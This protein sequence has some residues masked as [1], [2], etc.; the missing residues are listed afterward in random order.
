MFCVFWR[1]SGARRGA[2]TR[3][4][5]ARRGACTR[6]P[7]VRVRFAPSPTGFLH[8]G[9]LRTALYNYLFAKQRRGT[10]IL[11]LEDTDRDRLVPGAADAIEDM[12]EWAGIPP[13]ESSRRGGHYGPYVQSERLHL[14]SQ[15]TSSLL[16]TGHAYYCFCTN[17]RL[18]L[19]KR[20]AQR[21]GHAPR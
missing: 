14:Y 17:Q 19:L 7:E 4:P 15:A 11:R 16:H 18:E 8:L 9:G 5:G 3:Q 12:L 1:R 13:D 10:F 6:Q 21:S 20:E 2:C